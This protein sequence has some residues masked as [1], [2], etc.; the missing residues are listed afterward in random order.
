MLNMHY[1]A[2]EFKIPLCPGRRWYRS[3][4]TA[5]PSPE[6]ISDL[7]DEVLIEGE[8][9]LVTPRSVVVLISK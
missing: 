2:L 3:V 6:D 9:Y 4:D 1:D 8:G 5:L 7:G